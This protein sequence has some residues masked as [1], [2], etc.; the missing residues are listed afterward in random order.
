MSVNIRNGSVQDSN[1]IIKLLEQGARDGHYGPSLSFQAKEF[2]QSILE[3]G[4][5]RLVKARGSIK[6]PVVIEADVLVAEFGETPASFI[7]CFKEQGEVEIHLAGTVKEFRGKG[8]FRKL[9][10]EA[11]KKYQGSKIYARCYEKSSWAIQALTK[12]GLKVTKKGNPVE[13]TL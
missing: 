6:A 10:V 11:I 4:S 9:T 8:C 2:M 5:V 12:L 3:T 13:L 7:I 1:W